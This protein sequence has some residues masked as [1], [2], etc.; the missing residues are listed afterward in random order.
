MGC[1]KLMQKGCISEGMD[2]GNLYGSAYIWLVFVV[3]MACS[4]F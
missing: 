3:D 1:I 4:G 2:L